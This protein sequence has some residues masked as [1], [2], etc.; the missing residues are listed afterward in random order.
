MDDDQ[1]TDV[2]AFAS[3]GKLVPLHQAADS[4]ARTTVLGPI[5]RT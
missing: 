3:P 5:K 1:W 4:Q 2:P